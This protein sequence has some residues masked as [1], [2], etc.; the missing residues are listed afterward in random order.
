MV[1]L[2]KTKAW[3]AAALSQARPKLAVS[4]SFYLCLDQPLGNTT[5]AHWFHLTVI[6]SGKP[7]KGDLWGLGDLQRQW[8]A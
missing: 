8:E 2:L 7:W 3:L 6:L 5:L 4:I 1:L